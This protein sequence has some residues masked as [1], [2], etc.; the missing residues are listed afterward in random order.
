MAGSPRLQWLVI[1]SALLSFLLLST[2]CSGHAIY[3]I[4][5]TPN[6]LCPEDPCFTLSEYAQQSPHHLTS[7]TTLLLLP[8]DHALSV[9]LTVENVSGFE[10]FS[11]ADSHATRI[12]CQALVGFSFRNISHLTMHGLTISSCGMGTIIS[13]FPTAYGV[14][15]YSVLDT[16]IADCSFQD[17]DG[18]ALGVFHSSL[19]LRG[20]NHFTNNC[21]RCGMDNCSCIGGGIF[22][23]MSTLMFT[24]NNMFIAN[25]A[26]SGGG[27]Y[28]ISNTFITF[29]G[30]SILRNNLAE[31]GGGIYVQNSIINFSGNYTFGNNSAIHSGGGIYALYT[32][33]T[34]NGYS[35]FS[36]NSAG[37]GGG[38][39]AQTG[40]VSFSGSYTF[41]NNSAARHGGGI[42]SVSDTLMTFNGSSIF[43]SNSAMYGGGI[44]AH[45]SSLNLSGSIY[46][47]NNSAAH[48]GGGIDASY[49]TFITFS[50]NSILRNNSAEVGGGIYVQNSIINFSGNYTFGNNSA[51]H[52]GGGKIWQ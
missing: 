33:M 45:N 5:P 25:S 47:G 21:R 46:F 22:A 42:N 3:Y 48:Y 44:L 1:A 11:S 15:I 23:N 31:V 32:L 49:N 29:S 40:T 35:I 16:R 30:N 39:R 4:K 12:V 9:N 41:G 43:R 7:N 14:S 37:H 2:I 38:I 8:G 10:V 20:S 19:D 51:I 28:A 24:G 34:F 6:T 27:I 36:S 18:T 13:S 50:G 52:C 17:S 26:K